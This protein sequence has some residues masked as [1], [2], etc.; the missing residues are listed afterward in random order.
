MLAISAQTLVYQRILRE[1]GFGARSRPRVRNHKHCRS[2]TGSKIESVSV[3]WRAP[4]K[5]KA[6]E[7]SQVSV[8]SC[9]Y[10][11][12]WKEEMGNLTPTIR[13]C[14]Q[15]TNIIVNAITTSGNYVCS[16]PNIL[17]A[18]EY[19]HPLEDIVVR[20]KTAGE[21]GAAI[22]SLVCDSELGNLNGNLISESNGGNG[23]LEN[24]TGGV[25]LRALE[26]DVDIGLDVDNPPNNARVSALGAWSLVAPVPFPVVFIEV[27]IF[28]LV[29]R[30][31]QGDTKW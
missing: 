6:Y 7:G 24:S 9:A 5:S 21:K 2:E 22:R 3:K 17:N 28:R 15:V 11:A 14:D 23:V 1:S 19:G 27:L 26:E 20:V 31:S 10:K 13:K 18:L 25:E 8:C 30:W 4:K 16:H 29:R 12:Q